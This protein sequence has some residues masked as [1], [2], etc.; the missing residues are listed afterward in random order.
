M[1]RTRVVRIGIVFAS[2]VAAG[3]LLTMLL[4]GGIVTDDTCP[5]PVPPIV[6]RTVGGSG[7]LV[8]LADSSDYFY[9]PGSPQAPVSDLRYELARYRPGDN[10]LGLGEIIREGRLDSLNRTGDLQFHDMGAEGEFSPGNDF[11]ILVDPPPVTLQLRIL[12]PSG[13]AIAWNMIVFCA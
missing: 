2:F 13:K 11:F 6:L 10:H 4:T 5:I 9:A 7:E 8:F 12:D 1:N 3:I